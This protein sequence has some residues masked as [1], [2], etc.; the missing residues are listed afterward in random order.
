[1]PSWADQPIPER[2]LR[3]WGRSAWSW[4]SPM[5]LRGDHPHAPGVVYL[6]V[7]DEADT[8]AVGDTI[9]ADAERVSELYGRLHMR[10][11]RDT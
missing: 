4:C 11:M 2:V 10:L 9:N 6:V 7:V 5:R 8:H 1:M 3:T